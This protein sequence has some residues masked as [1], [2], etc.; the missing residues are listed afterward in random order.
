MKLSTRL[1]LSLG[2]VTV[3]GFSILILITTLQTYRTTRNLLEESVAYQAGEAAFRLAGP[4]EEALAKTSGI[5]SALGSIRGLTSPRT[6]ALNMLE[7]YLDD[8]PQLDGVWAVFAPDSFNG[9]DAPFA[10]QPGSAEDGRF[11]PYWNTFGGSKALEYCVSY[12][13]PGEYGLYYQ[14]A[15]KTGKNY[16]TKPTEYEIAGQLL[17]VV[18]VTVPIRRGGRIIGTA[19]VDFSMEA[20]RNIISSIRPYEIGYAYL[21]SDDGT[22]SAHPDQAL[23]GTTIQE[24]PVLEGRPEAASFVQRLKKGDNWQMEWREGSNDFLVLQRP[25]RF[26]GMAELWSMGYAIPLNVVLQPVRMLI[27]VI[28]LIAL[29]ATAAVVVLSIYLSLMVTKPIQLI[30][31]LARS[32]EDGDLQVSVDPRLQKRQDEL[33]TLAHAMG[34]TIGKLREVVEDVQEAVVSVNESSLNLSGAAQQMSV[35]IAGIS[36]SSQQLSQGST[37]QAA[38]AEEVSASVEQMS[39]NIRQNADN[40]GQTEGI[41]VKAAKD[42]IE[43]LQAMTETVTA[44]KQIAEKIAII[45]EIAR[46]TNMLSLNASIEAARAGEHGKGF[47]VVAAEVGK[48]AERSRSAAGQISAL[49]GSSVAI[50]EHA[51]ALL[52][53]M[54]PDIQ[55]T[56][57]LVQEISHASREQDTGAHQISQAMNQLDSV[58]QH[59]AAIS[60]EFSST[61]EQIAAQSET[62]AATAEQLSRQAETLSRVM[63][64]FRLGS[65]AKRAAGNGPAKTA[66]SRAGS[67]PQKAYSSKPVAGKTAPAPA[68]ARSTAITLPKAA[69][70]KRF[71]PTEE[72]SDDEF[73][74]F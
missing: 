9:P 64:F 43:G 27:V 26:S 54:A 1:A 68:Q 16:I 45:E 15:Y 65:A 37:E 21:L 74:E 10:G 59:N 66:A 48:L 6:V 36:A 69:E 73:T 12:D 39:A 11:A 22:I 25:V 40:A 13:D 17:T 14:V 63:G 4:F 31:A 49:S 67:K 42:A 7:Q 19:G 60:E 3:A 47:A 57:D 44:M 38:S 71:R 35:G 55:R 46:Q 53:G 58:I 23:Q 29:A 41:A 8:N 72:V 62:V 30:T 20:V 24:L 18:S 50:A 51:G 61:S 2:L 32:L 5:A 56:A 33:G 28:L 52:S 34:A 70:E